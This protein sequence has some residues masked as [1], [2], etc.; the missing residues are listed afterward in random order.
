M[1][2]ISVV[3]T[4][5]TSG[6]VVIHGITHHIKSGYE[7]NGTYKKYNNLNVGLGY[8]SADGW[9][10]GAYHNSYEKLTVYAGKN[11]MWAIGPTLF[12]RSPEIGFTLIAATGYEH[13]ANSPIVPLA[14]F[15]LKLPIQERWSAVLTVAPVPYEKKGGST[16]LGTVSNLSLS[17]R[18]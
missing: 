16:I 17:Y 1:F 11:W 5:A 4:A 10:I 18:F 12:G 14:G 7:E 3:A 2:A 6:E 15:N 8:V 9:V 13:R